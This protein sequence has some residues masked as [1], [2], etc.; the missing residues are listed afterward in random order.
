MKTKDLLV[1]G[2][3]FENASWRRW[4]QTRFN[5]DRPPIVQ[6]ESMQKSTT[7][8]ATALNEKESQTPEMQLTKLELEKKLEKETPESIKEKEGG[9]SETQKEERGEL[10]YQQEH[11][12]IKENKK[13]SSDFE[14]VKR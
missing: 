1:N 11:E 5:I 13:N 14:T 9:K 8:T 3:R 12:S 7:T 6:L 2:N 10:S 4:Y